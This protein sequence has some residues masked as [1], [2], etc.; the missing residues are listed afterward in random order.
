MRTLLGSGVDATMGCEGP[1]EGDRLGKEVGDG[2]RVG[3]DA[4]EGVS[5]TW[6]LSEFEA[7]S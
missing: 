5:S 1:G 6:I 7:Q 3:R 2:E 4:G